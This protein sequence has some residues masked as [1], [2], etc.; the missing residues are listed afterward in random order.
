[1]VNRVF[2]ESLSKTLIYNSVN[3]VLGGLPQ[4]L[5][6]RSLFRGKTGAKCLMRLVL[7]LVIE[8]AAVLT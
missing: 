7:D 3:V 5:W 8:P 6:S 1:V 2:S 4:P